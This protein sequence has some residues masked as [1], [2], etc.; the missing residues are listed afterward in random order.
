MFLSPHVP[1]H[2]YSPNHSPAPY[3]WKHRKTISHSAFLCHSYCHTCIL[4]TI[5]K[6]T[7]KVNSINPEK[8][9]F[10]LTVMKSSFTTESPKVSHLHI[11]R[12]CTRR[13]ERAA[14]SSRQVWHRWMDTAQMY[15]Q[16]GWSGCSLSQKGVW[17]LVQNYQTDQRRWRKPRM[18]LYGSKASSN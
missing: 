9:R 17:T 18:N 7:T 16:D 2:V 4:N 13:Q 5:L 15:P 11:L 10:W 14:G 6:N 1:L 12:V 8:F 3:S